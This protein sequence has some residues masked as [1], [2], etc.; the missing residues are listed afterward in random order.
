MIRNLED[1]VW[2]FTH[3]DD[4]FGGADVEVEGVIRHAIADD[5]GST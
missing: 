4:K 3:H 1:L 5:R 2:L